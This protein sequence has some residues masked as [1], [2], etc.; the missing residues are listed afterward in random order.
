MKNYKEEFDRLLT[1]VEEGTPFAF[2]R[3]SDGEVTILRNKTVVLA[4]DYFIQGDIHGEQKNFANSYPPEEQKSFIP[5]FNKREHQKLV[6][7]FKFRKN[8][9]IKGIPGQNSLDGGRSWKFCTELYGPD[10]WGNLS[11]ANVM[12]NGNYSRFINEMIPLFTKM[13]IVLIANEN[14][15]LNELPFK[16]KKFFS[17]GGNC[18]VNNFDLPNEVGEWIRNNNIKN[19]LFLFSAAT[20]SNYLCYDLFREHDNNQYM[21]IGSSLGPLLQ[22]EGWKS[23]RTYLLAYWGNVDHPVLHEEDVWK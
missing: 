8:N 11:F 21:D 20:L 1:F 12:I 7:A 6:E 3:F 16:V 22:L 17:V 5:F 19:H 9:Y 23:S 15:K 18:M 10:D 13:E 14:S 2:S 4:E